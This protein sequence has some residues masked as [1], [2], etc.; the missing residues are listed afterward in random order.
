MSAQRRAAKIDAGHLRITGIAQRHA[1]R[2]SC[3]KSADAHA[4]RFI[5]NR[6]GAA[7]SLIGF[8]PEAGELKN[9]GHVTTA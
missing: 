4:S 8:R 3:A 5:G 9:K 2:R 6:I 1:R 7:G